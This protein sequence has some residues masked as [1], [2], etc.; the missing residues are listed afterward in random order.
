MSVMI[1][2]KEMPKSCKDCFID[3][4]ECRLWERLN[5]TC[6]GGARH[7]KCPLAEAPSD[8]I[9]R[10]A[11]V[12]EIHAIKGKITFQTQKGFELVEHDIRRTLDRVI[13]M[14]ANAVWNM[15]AEDE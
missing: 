6:Y 10:R 1:K 14:A 5:D 4:N 8:A 15:E 12:E 7:P 2:N 13:E 11:A 9:S 3:E